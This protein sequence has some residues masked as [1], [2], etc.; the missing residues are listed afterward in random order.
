MNVIRQFLLTPNSILDVGCNVGV[1]LNHC[2]KLWPN[3]RLAGID[4]NETSLATAKLRV[5]AGDIRRSG[6]ESI[7][8]DDGSFEYVTCIEVLEHLPADLRSSAFAE[9]RRCLCDGGKLVMTVPHAGLFSWLD[10]NNI[11]FRFPAIYRWFVGRGKRDGNYEKLARKVEW[12]EHF[13][14]EELI[15]LAGNGWELHHVERGGLF[16]YPL[17]DWLSWPFYK[18]GLSNNPIRL[19]FEKIAGWDYSI[20]FGLASYGILIVLRKK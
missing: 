9:M 12:H 5:P 13:T 15:A 11:R 2:S 19:M 16:L 14:L 7:P 8:F 1:W 3:T 10:S 18:M 6:A 17:M 20:N 4:I